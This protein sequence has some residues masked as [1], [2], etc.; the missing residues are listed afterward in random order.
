MFAC[1]CHFARLGAEQPAVVSVCA[2]ASRPPLSVQHRCASLTPA[3][4]LH[5][6]RSCRYEG[7]TSPYIYP[8]Y[9]LGELPQ[10]GSVCTQA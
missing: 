4:V 2:V 6:L 7:L 8:L 10:V 1:T 5:G 9:G 3:H